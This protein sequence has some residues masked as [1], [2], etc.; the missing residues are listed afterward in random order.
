MERKKKEVYT[1]EAPWE[2]YSLDWSERSDINKGFRLAV[3]SFVEAYTNC[4]DILMHDEATDSLV[5]TARFDHP[6][7]TTKVMWMPDKNNAHSDMIATTGDYL[8]LWSVHDGG[9][10]VTMKSILN[11]NK[12]R[13]YCAPLTSFDWNAT[14]PS[15][16][17]T[18]SIDTTCTIWDIVA[19]KTRT[20][21]IAH[22]EEV[23]DI[24]FAPGKDIFASVGADGS[25]R[26]FDLRELEHS[27]I[28]YESPGKVPLLRLEWNKQDPNYIATVLKN[29][30][31]TVILDIRKPATPVCELQAHRAPVNAVTWAPHS[32]VHLCS[33]GDD[34][35]TLIWRLKDMPRT[36]DKPI[37]SYAA[38]AEI[39]NLKWSN[40]TRDWVAIAF[41]NKVQMLRV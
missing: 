21:L 8:R 29:S 3:G 6:Y 11:N 24:A 15:L 38:E 9:T 13:E 32:S 26:M 40:A 37:L 12:K 36:L 17:G 16:I 39:N 22:D 30:P 4:V 5:Q 18:S 31:V 41:K 20:Q 19:E 2:V 23:Y 27:T 1:Y 28:I 33:A 10:S 14:D 35:H 25:V 7:P 34:R